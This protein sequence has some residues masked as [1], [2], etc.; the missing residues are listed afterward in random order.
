MFHHCFLTSEGS[1]T[2]FMMAEKVF[3]NNDSWPYI[4]NNYSDLDV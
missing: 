3:F 2:R 4:V 1:G